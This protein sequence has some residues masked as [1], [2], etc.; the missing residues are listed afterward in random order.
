MANKIL[1]VAPTWREAIPE[2]CGSNRPSGSFSAQAS[3]VTTYHPPCL[4]IAKLD[5]LTLLPASRLARRQ[6]RQST[7]ASVT[8]ESKDHSDRRLIFAMNSYLRD[9]NTKTS[10]PIP[11]YVFKGSHYSRNGIEPP[12]RKPGPTRVLRFCTGE[13]RIYYFG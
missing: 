2:E 12:M 11:G 3:S 4:K 5:L 9:V 13:V 7:A 8:E 1:A 6:G 10:V